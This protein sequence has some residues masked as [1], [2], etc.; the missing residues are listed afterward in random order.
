MATPQVKSTDEIRAEFPALERTEGGRPVAYF[1]GPGGTQVPR[2]VGEAMTDYLFQ[3]NA[4]THWAYP[5]SAETDQILSDARATFAAFLNAAPDE[6]AFG[7]NMTTLALHVSRAIG[8]RIRPTDEVVVTELD[9]H[10]NV[11][12]WTAIGVERDIV[13]KW[14]RLDPA[15]GTLDW[16]HLLSLIG[17]RTRLVAIGAASNA[18]G[19]ISDVREVAQ[20]A[21]AVGAHVFVDGV[22][23]APHRLPDVRA[24]ECDFF[25]CSPYK[26]YG[27]HIGVLFVRRKVMADLPFAR[28]EPAPDAPPERA[29]TGTLNHEGIVGAAAAVRW[30]GGLASGQDL[31]ARLKRTYDVLD[32]RGQDQ[33]AV[34]W[35]SLGE[36]PGVR[37]YGPPP[38]APRTA[39]VAFTVRDVPSFQVTRRL[40]RR[41]VFTSH[42]DFYAKT[43][44]DLLGLQ[45]EGLV[46]AG[47][48]CYTTDEEVARLV[49]GVRAIAKTR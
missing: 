12:P 45:P 21:H 24:L 20:R 27:P 37:L 42:G 16:D 18:L 11:A 4:N 30:L 19:T 36:I 15:S 39:T 7:A 38:D 2:V 23:Y 3:H 22:H 34:L 48:A 17:Q 43:V 14:A 26:F 35:D 31:R 13:I 8:R 28:L 5:S 49:S 29:E 32:E 1:D 6:I 9:H 47:C 10:A 25:A 46:R 41:G 44:V 40:A 33:F